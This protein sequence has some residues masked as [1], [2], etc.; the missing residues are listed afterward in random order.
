MIVVG[1]LAGA[2]TST[3]SRGIQ[4]TAALGVVAGYPVT[5]VRV[6]LRDVSSH[7]VDSQRGA[8]F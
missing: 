8:T 6:E 3:R 5:D 2:S 7:E 1:V 4:E